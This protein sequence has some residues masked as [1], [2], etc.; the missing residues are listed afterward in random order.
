MENFFT[1]NKDIQLLFNNTDLTEVIDLKEGDYYDAEEFDYA[2]TDAEDAR[3]G[4][5]EILTLTG[6][7]S[8]QNIAPLAPEVD[9]E[10]CHFN[11]GTVTYPKG[12]Q[13]SMDILRRSNLMGFT[14]PRKYGGLNLPSFV[15][16]IGIEM[17]SQAD[18]S[19]MSIFGLQDIA[20]TINEFGDEEIKSRYLP[21]FTSGKVTGAMALTEPDAGSDLQAV[22]L[23]ATFH[24][25]EN[26][27]HLN[28]VKRFITNGCGD[29]LL[30]LARSEPGTRD[31]RGLSMFVCEKNKSL[32]V[33]R[34]EDKLGI[35]GSPTC[36]LQFNNTRAYLVGKRRLGL[37]RYV[38]SLMNGARV[39]ISAQGV[40][41]AQAAYL[42]G[43]EYARAREQF[44]TA[45]VNIPLVYEMLINARVSI[46]AARL[47]LY[48]TS[49]VVDLKKGYEKKLE[50]TDT[51][52]KELRQTSKY[53]N[54]LAA[55]LTPISKYISTEYANKVAYDMLQVHGGTGYMNDFNIERH[56]R[57]ARITNIYEGTTQLQI[58]AAIG[59]VVT[60]VMEPELDKIEAL[61]VE[62]FQKPFLKELKEKR[63]L[64]NRAID[65]VKEMDDH[66]YQSYHSG[67][68]VDMAAKV[69][70]SYL[71][72]KYAPFSDDKKKTTAIYFEREMPEIEKNFAMITSGNRGS[73]AEYSDLLGNS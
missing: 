66:V 63:E 2:F 26:V 71:F 64:L 3:E 58:V 43:L 37:I 72:L 55:L 12:I 9:E 6:E 21:Y 8:A 42:E 62:D 18:A 16:S 69:H 57:D 44:G 68:L 54:T 17:V 25:S 33:R 49:R 11:S 28:G 27:W 34:I 22:Q 23:K 5:R 73:I 50:M 20:D 60:R 56:Y 67:R 10:G 59:G 48:D 7:I 51:P 45:I 41:I 52:T 32:V 29:V 40:G 61:L 30:V 65:F 1:D 31:G 15:Y 70:T 24:E 13:K 4:Y 46:E 47:L 39:C 35:H 53:Y 19:L 14:L 36:E 38:I